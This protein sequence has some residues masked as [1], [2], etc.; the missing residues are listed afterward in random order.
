MW[1]K[2]RDNDCVSNCLK[3]QVSKLVCNVGQGEDTVTY[4]GNEA[5]ARFIMAIATNEGNPPS[6]RLEALRLIVELMEKEN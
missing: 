6:V 3:K 5:I 2:K 1:K 4:K